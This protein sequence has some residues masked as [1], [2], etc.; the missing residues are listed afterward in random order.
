MVT[1]IICEYNPMHFGHIHHIAESKKV[2]RA[3]FIVCLMSGNFVQRGEAAILD[4]YT[5]AEIAIESGADLVLELPFHIATTSAQYFA[6]GGV[7]ILHE[8]GFVSAMCFGSESGDISELEEAAR[9]I[10]TKDAWSYI[11]KG[12]RTGKS[13]CEARGEYLDDKS[14]LFLGSNNILAIEYLRSLMSIDEDIKYYREAEDIENDK[15]GFCRKH[16]D[17][18]KAD[19]KPMQAFT[20]KR[21]GESCAVSSSDI[22]RA[23]FLEEDISQRVPDKVLAAVEAEIEEIISSERVYFKLVMNA[24]SDRFETGGASD[25]FSA[26]NGIEHRAAKVFRSCSYLD[27]LVEKTKTRNYASS[28]IK[29]FL[30]HTVVNYRKGKYRR[31]TRLLA[32]N[33]RGRY[34]LKKAKKDDSVRLPI[35]S[36]PVEASRYELEREISLEIRANDVYSIIRRRNLYENS[37]FV[38]KP[39]ML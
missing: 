9:I 30:L 18:G 17:E 37:D 33:D 5:R 38:R 11:S 14:D 13:F 19:V 23:I 16:E 6:S 10:D 35:I 22:R 12:I 24:L 39:V 2:S 29:R 3:D 28:R 31:Y 20:V 1:G 26:G 21:S 32:A 27:E 4:K 36:S 8:L 15:L 34:L 7:K 25:I